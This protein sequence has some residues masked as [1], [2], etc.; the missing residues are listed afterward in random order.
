LDSVECNPSKRSSLTDYAS[1][2][3]EY[4]IKGRHHGRQFHLGDPARTK[5]IRIDAFRGEIDFE[6]V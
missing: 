5:I 6:L 1:Y 3:K 2:E 4:A